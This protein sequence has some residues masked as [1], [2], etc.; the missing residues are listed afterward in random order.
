[1]KNNTALFMSLCLETLGFEDFCTSSECKAT[2]QKKYAPPNLKR[3]IMFKINQISYGGTAAIVTS[4]AFIVGLDAANASRNTIISALLIASLADN[5]TDSLSIHIY[6]ESERLEEHEAFAGT[7]TNFAARL[8]ICLS[9]V[10]LVAIFPMQIAI[11]AALIYGTLLLGGLSYFLARV[12]RVGATSEVLK[13][14]VVAFI[15]IFVSKGIGYWIS[16]QIAA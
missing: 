5:L 1:M 11:A 16:R 15:V 9:F 13:H 8:A 7:L 12:R 6:Q 10:L 4:M 3:T 2:L 14:L